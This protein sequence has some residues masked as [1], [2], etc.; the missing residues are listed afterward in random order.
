MRKFIILFVVMF[1]SLQA[2]AQD[3]I[4]KDVNVIYKEGK[5]TIAGNSCDLLNKEG[6]ALAKWSSKLKEKTKDSP[7]SCKS[8]YCTKDV[9]ELVPDF[10]QANHSQRNVVYG[11]NSF[12]AALH[13][14]KI[15]SQFR[16]ASGTEMNFWMN[17]PLCRER[18]ASEPLAPG[19]L[20]LIRS[21]KDGDLHG[22]VHVT[23][24]LAFS[25]NGFDGGNPYYL[26]SPIAL[27]DYNKVPENCRKRG[28]TPKE[29]SAW[30]NYFT[31]KTMD[32]YLKERPIKS[33]D[34][35]KAY[36]QLT[37]LECSIGEA[38][39]NGKVNPTIRTFIVDNLVILN[40]MAFDIIKNKKFL[41]EDKVIWQAIF[42]KTKSI[43]GQLDHI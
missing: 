34:A 24:N 6:E 36:A 23:N 16:Y 15:L 39:V 35:K 8:G 38:V 28:G 18:G 9:T 25:K 26:Q 27:H 12:N 20:A 17:S 41:E 14:S 40:N 43:S 21:W 19:D 3:P 42:H 33:S 11:P 7:C 29:C 32:E 1:S 5:L 13:S 37:E 2:L 10:V 30:V 31:C 4:Y 22:Y